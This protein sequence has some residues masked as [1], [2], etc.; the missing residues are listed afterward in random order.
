MALARTST[1][2]EKSMVFVRWLLP[3]AYLI[4]SYVIVV[5]I[6][7][8]KFIGVTVRACQAH[9]QVIITLGDSCVVEIDADVAV[10]A[11]VVVVV[12][13]AVDVAVDVVDVAG[14]VVADG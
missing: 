13:V 8:G 2:S 1:D 11:V 4:R 3:G 14:R 9:A 10:A 12:D 7:I 6:V 5:K